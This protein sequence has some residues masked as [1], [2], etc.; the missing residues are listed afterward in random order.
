MIKALVRLKAG[1]LSWSM[2]KVSR[3]VTGQRCSSGSLHRTKAAS[4]GE[5]WTEGKIF[6]AFPGPSACLK[7]L[8]IK[9]STHLVT[10]V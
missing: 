1:V 5:P 2:I 9:F 3:R 8:V 6:G 10:S 4:P 7:A